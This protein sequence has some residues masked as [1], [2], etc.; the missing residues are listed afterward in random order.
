VRP[1]TL[2]QRAE[3]GQDVLLS[4]TA[5]DQRGATG[6]HTEPFSKSNPHPLV[7]VSANKSLYRAGEPIEVEI[8]ASEP[9]MTLVMNVAQEWKVIRSQVVRLR[10]GRAAIYLPYSP[11]FKGEITISA[12][13]DLSPGFNHYSYS[14][15]ARTV[16]YPHDRELK[17]D[18][19]S[20]QVTYRP[21]DEA[22]V[23]VRVR[24]ADGQAVEGALGVVVFDKAVEARART[25]QEFGVRYGFYG[26]LQYPW[27]NSEELAGVRL[28]DLYR[29]DLSKPLPEGLELL[30]EVILLHRGLYLPPVSNMHDETDLRRIFAPMLEPQLMPIR[31]ALATRYASQADYPVD[32]PDLRRRLAESGIHFDQLRDPWGTPYRTA[33]TVQR[34]KHVFKLLSAGADKRF[35][36]DDDFVVFTMDWSY[37]QRHGDAI[38][39]AVDEY[40]ARTGGFIRDST[41]LKAELL[42]KGI[43]FD[44]LRDAWGQPYALQFGVSGPQFTV[45]VRSG[46]PNRRFDKSDDL[47][48]DDFTIWTARINYFAELSGRIS[49]AL[50]GYFRSTKCPPENQA[51]WR[52]ALERS[53]M[54]PDSLRD[55]W[56]RPYYLRF[57]R[58]A[59]YSDRVV[60]QT[61][62]NDGGAATQRTTL[63]P[64]TQ[65]VLHIYVHSVGEDGKQGTADDFEVARFLQVTAEQMGLD[66]SPQ[67]VTGRATLSDLVGAISGAVTDPTGAALPGVTVTA[68][69]ASTSSIHETVSNEAGAYLLPNLPY[70]SYQVRFDLAG[71]QSSVVA[72]VPVRSSSTTILNAMLQVGT[73][74]QLV[75]V[76]AETSIQGRATTQAMLSVNVATREERTAANLSSRADAAEERMP[77]AT[78]R[79]REDFPETLLWQPALETDRRGRAQ[80]KFRLADSITTWKLAIIG[81]TV[82]G[83]IGTAEKELRAFQPFFIEHD[84]PRVLTEGDEIALPIVLRNYLDKAQAVDLE[85][86]PEGWFKL[87]EPAR[88]RAQVAAGD[89]VREIFQFHA[90]TSVAR[91]KQRVTATGPRASDAVEKTVS[92][93]PDGE[94]VAQTTGQIFGD[95]A[96]LDVSIPDYAMAGTARAELKIYPNLMAHA[97][98]GIEGILQRPYGCAEQ[99]ISSTY[100]NLIVLRYLQR[101]S[102]GAPPVAVKAR[103]YVQAGYERLLGY[104]AE[105]GGFSYWGRG[106]AD[107]ALTAHALKF[108][109]DASEFVTV[110]ETVTKRARVWLIGQ[111][112]PDGSWPARNW[113]GSEDER[114]THLLTAYITRV[115]AAMDAGPD[116]RVGPAASPNAV[117]RA[118]AY[119]A[120]RVDEIDEPYLIASYTL[121]AL[122]AGGRARAGQALVRLRALAHDESDASYWHL[123]SN[124]PFY[125][126]GLAGRVETT[127]LAMRALVHAREPGRADLASDPL[128]YRALRFLLRHKDRYGVWYS[129]QA[130]VNVLDALLAL[131]EAASAPANAGG[132]AEVLVNGR[133]VTSVVMPD[134]HQLSNP[135]TVELSTFLAASGTHVEIRRSAGQARASAQIV[136][137][138]YV[139]WSKSEATV[140]ENFKPGATRGLRLAAHFDKSTVQVGEEVTCTVAAERAGARGYGMLLAEI[141]LP[142][143]AEVDRAS[144]D[145]AMSASGWEMNRYDVLPDRLVV[146]LWPRAGGTRFQFKFRPRFGL[147]AKSAPSLL[148]DYYN[149]EARA[150]LAP[151]EFVVK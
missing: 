108:L 53:G 71:F 42:R 39:R 97:F 78:P 20:S 49:T 77:M 103:R 128:V 85:I 107:L 46:G 58:Q 104:R 122:D 137:T 44:A 5:A 2:G 94:E 11:E 127:A 3:R 45:S 151:A 22:Q 96:T 56:G 21:G 84:P 80:L 55:P 73:V 35:G 7:R 110:D 13:D 123:E 116:Q 130:T 117:T 9:D 149:P 87:L 32:E 112:R 92:V 83:E 129:T 135:I 8:T 145:Q 67:P 125:G 72:Y 82:S 91:G 25:D 47:N 118:L 27:N 140:D 29:L 48:S 113:Q 115:L 59:R 63:T 131:D 10:K 31:E 144:L 70:G 101:V 19:R 133:H 60:I 89:S 93:H 17:L 12:Y 106:A 75:V 102:E 36:T 41:T 68:T 147:I 64:V 119:L 38:N 34:E 18:V 100:L 139:P 136:V 66:Q 51:E 62:A 69:H 114:G 16:L 30:A 143:G 24:T 105:G 121:A 26:G 99:I 98:E 111:Q 65:Q 4:F 37:F 79:L 90:V 14:Y 28:H 57:I 40:H 1:L 76:Q 81:S 43:D 61:R 95:A 124:T 23:D 50:D 150:V 33:F 146:Y 74:D 142:P 86:K 132:A 52:D 120:S 15:G 126:W 138:Y 88:K 148:Y 109:K 54:D 134:G 141:G 6:H